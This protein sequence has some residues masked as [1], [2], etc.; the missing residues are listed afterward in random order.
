MTGVLKAYRDCLKTVVLDR[1]T[2]F[3][4]VIDYQTKIASKHQDGSKYFILLILTDGKI[5][6]FEENKQVLFLFCIY[7]TD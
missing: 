4:E 3:A 2:N 1:P 5:T 6:N 7:K